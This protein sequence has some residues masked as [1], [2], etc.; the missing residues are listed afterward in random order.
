MRLNLI[1]TL[2]LG[3]VMS[4]SSAFAQKS[5]SGVVKDR[6]GNPLA[7]ANVFVKGTTISTITGPS[8]EFNISAA[9]DAVLVI[10]F[11]GYQNMEVVVAD[12][13]TANLQ[14]KPESLI[15]I[16]AYYGNDNY[17]ELTTASTLINTDDIGTG[18]ETDIYQYL[19]GKVPGL[20]VIPDA[21]GSVHYRMRGG[22]SPTGNVAEP[23]FV[24]DGLYDVG[25]NSAVNALNPNDIE[26]IRVLKDVAATAQYGQYGRNGVI[27]IKTRHPSDKILAV[28]YDGN[29]SL[30]VYDDDDKWADYDRYKNSLSTKHNVDVRGL[31]GPM[32]YRAALGYNSIGGMFDN[33]KE[34]RLSGSVWLGP[35]LL[36][37]HLSI[38]FNS[39]YRKCKTTAEEITTDNSQMT[40]ILK[41]DYSVHSLEDLHLNLFAAYNSNLDNSS[42]IMLDGNVNL[43]HQFG[44]AYYLEL[45][46]GAAAHIYDYEYNSPTDLTSFYGQLNLALNRYFLN[47]NSRYNVLDDSSYGKLTSAVSMG[48]KVSNSVVLRSGFGFSGFVIGSRPDGVSKLDAFSY[49]FGFEGGSSKSVVNG[50]AD[51]YVHHNTESYRYNASEYKTMSLNNVGGDFRVS[52]KLIDTD[53]VKWRFGGSV[54]INICTILDADDYTN[55]IVNTAS[56]VDWGPDEKPITFYAY[57]HVY[58]YDGNPIPNAYVDHN[59]NDMFDSGD[60]VS[61]ECSAVPMVVGGFN[62]Y[63]EV[64]GG[65]LQVNAHGSNDKYN[66]YSETDS[67]VMYIN[68]IYGSSFLRFDNIVLG[69]RF[70]NLWLFSGRAYMAVENPFVITPY[71]G[72]DPEIYNGADDHSIRQR[73]TIFS[74]G[75]KLN[76]NI[77]D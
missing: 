18:L 14:L 40:A 28:S 43:H 10:S 20:E 42:M 45:R 47:F 44:K 3:L 66:I 5:V 1:F 53:K 69:Y 2:A 30:N 71:A 56:S 55:S 52:A 67:D 63:F 51:F 19:L 75:V 35:R 59:G 62:T 49:N 27:V 13:A 57:D 16:G 9:D 31:A 34:N 33:E 17:Y 46:A 68:D 38:D 48:V 26:S 41:T 24:V 39:Y 29:A 37:K 65:Y 77:K 12:L 25:D 61:S 21:S 32:P 11:E 23:L 7:G 70:S 58:D 72:R 22:D 73:P 6:G 54:A 60:L 50:S 36:D 8:G 64:M 74:V 15:G 76:V 4:A